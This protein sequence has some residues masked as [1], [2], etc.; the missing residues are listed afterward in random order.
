M[1][2]G[3]TAALVA[4][5]ASLRVMPLRRWALHVQ[6][7]LEGGLLAKVAE[8]SELRPVITRTHKASACVCSAGP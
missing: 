3:R 8:V 7:Q 1:R 2:T 5:L 4:T 6:V